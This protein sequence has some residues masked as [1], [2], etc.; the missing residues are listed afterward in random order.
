M[1]AIRP[2]SSPAICV[3]S[4]SSPWYRA[5][6]AENSMMYLC[7]GIIKY[8]ETMALQI[9]QKRCFLS[10]DAFRHWPKCFVEKRH[11]FKDMFSDPEVWTDRVIWWR[12]KSFS[13]SILMPTE[14]KTHHPI[15]HCPLR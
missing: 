7:A 9:R 14:A 4:T 2:Y 12:V 15:S 1:P 6:F 11:P 8:L 5:S 10:H 3:S 13:V